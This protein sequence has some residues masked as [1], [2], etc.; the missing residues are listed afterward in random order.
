MVIIPETVRQPYGFLFKISAPNYS[1]A[2]Y[3]VIAA[4]TFRTGG[5]HQV[6]GMT[7]PAGGSL[8][9]EAV[10]VTASRMRPIV[11]GRSP[12]TAAVTLAARRS[13]EQAGM[14]GWFGVTGTTR[15][16][17][18]PEIV[19]EVALRTGQI[20]VRAC[21]WKARESVIEGRRQPCICGMA[22]ATVRPEL[23]VV[24]IVFCVTGIAVSRCA[25]EE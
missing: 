15:H 6:D 7:I 13:R 20:G 8:M 19:V 24:V 3:R 18:G 5:G 2:A 12:G 4:V 23:T 21:Q 14:E 16:G 25:S 17:Q 22:G 10:P 11:S 1:I 9:V